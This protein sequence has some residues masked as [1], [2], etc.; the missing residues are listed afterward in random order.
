M[1]TL[2]IDWENTM[3]I[4]QIMSREILDVT[5]VFSLSGPM[6]CLSG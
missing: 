2:F 6:S 4:T 3:C 1:M 5:I